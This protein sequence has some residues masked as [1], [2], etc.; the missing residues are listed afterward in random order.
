[1]EKINVLFLAANPANARSQQRLDQ[2]ARE[3]HER[4]R[5]GTFRDAFNFTS[6][7]AVRPT[8]LQEALLRHR[9]QVLHFSAPRNKCQGLAL[10]DRFGKVKVLDKQALANLLGIFKTQI[11]LV[12]LNA[13]YSAPQVE[14]LSQVIDF[15][16][17]MEERIPEPSA[18]L[19]AASLYRAL[20]FGE[21]IN[22]AFSLARNDLELAN[23][24]G[25]AVPKLIVR[26]GS[27]ATR[28]LV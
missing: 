11:R 22:D 21:S 19:F 8:D 17:G 26:E 14:A 5:V 2:E 6:K 3:I 7:W 9:P 20:A 24:P 15:T 23:L 25:A 18:I 27:D 4:I 1:M 10:A 13:C 16:I 12:I 28:P